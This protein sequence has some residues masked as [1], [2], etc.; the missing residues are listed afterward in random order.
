MRCGYRTTLDS[1]EQAA[2]VLAASYERWGRRRSTFVLTDR[3]ARVCEGPA[4]TWVD[5]SVHERHD[6][7]SNMMLRYLARHDARETAA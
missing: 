6:A 5:G 2:S 1:Y 3:P 7:S 4:V